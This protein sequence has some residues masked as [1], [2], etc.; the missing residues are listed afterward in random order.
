MYIY[1]YVYSYN[2]KSQAQL[3]THDF[4]SKKEGLTKNSHT[5]IQFT[6]NPTE[7]TKFKRLIKLYMHI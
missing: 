7:A 2:W 4:F 1:I 6:Y 5:H 3:M